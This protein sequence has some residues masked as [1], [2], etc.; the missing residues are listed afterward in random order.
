MFRIIKTLRGTRRNIAAAQLKPMSARTVIQ[1]I[2]ASESSR[3]KELMFTRDDPVGK[4]QDFPA[5]FPGHGLGHCLHYQFIGS[6]FLKS[7]DWLVERK[8]TFNVQ[9]IPLCE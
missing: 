3:P 9:L 7:S 8:E 5:L 6:T 1:G 4:L 2:K